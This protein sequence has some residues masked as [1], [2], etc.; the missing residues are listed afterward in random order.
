MELCCL[1]GIHAG[2]DI[3]CPIPGKFPNYIK[4]RPPKDSEKLRKGAEERLRGD[5]HTVA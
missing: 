1:I 4:S 3:S 2:T 5:A